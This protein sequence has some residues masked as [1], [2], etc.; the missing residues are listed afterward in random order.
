MLPNEQVRDDLRRP[1]AEQLDDFEKYIAGEGATAEHAKQKAQRVRTL[2]DACGF[3]FA[4]NID[5]P[6][7]VAWLDGERRADRLSLASW[8]YYLRDAKSFCSWMVAHDR[9]LI[10]NSFR[11][12]RKIAGAAQP[13]RERG[14]S[15]PT[16]RA[17]S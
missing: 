3:Q 5:A 9:G 7:V 1:L 14:P 10:V 8:N 6:A 15:R 13:T 12:V 2:F 4:K 16:R 17:G 11:A